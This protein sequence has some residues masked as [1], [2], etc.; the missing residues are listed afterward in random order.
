MNLVDHHAILKNVDEPAQKLT[1]MAASVVDRAFIYVR[2]SGGS[3]S[4]S[5]VTSVALTFPRPR[6][7]GAYSLCKRNVIAFKNVSGIAYS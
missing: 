1:L 5:L 3:N 2:A 7:V 4:G 6:R